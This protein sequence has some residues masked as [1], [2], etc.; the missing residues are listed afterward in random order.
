VRAAPGARCTGWSRRCGS[1]QP[2]SPTT[3]PAPTPKA[4]YHG[5]RIATKLKVAGV[6]LAS[7]GLKHPEKEDDEFVRFSEPRRGVYKSVVIRDGKLG[8]HP[9]RRRREGR[10]TQSFDRGLPLPEERVELLFELAGSSGQEGAAEMDDS[11]QVCNCNGVSKGDLVACVRSGT[12]NVSG[13]MAATR[14]GKGCGV[15]KGLVGTVFRLRA[16]RGI[17]ALDAVCLHAGGPLADAQIDHMKI[18]CPLHSYTFSLSDGACRGGDLAVR[19]YPV[20][21][22]DGE[23]VVALDERGR[24]DFGRLQQRMHVIRPTLALLADVPVRYVVFDVL[25]RGGMPLLDEPYLA[26]RAV[27]AELDLDAR[28]FQTSPMFTDTPGGIVMTAARQQGIEGVIAKRVNSV[29]QPGRRSRAWIKTPIRYTAEVVLVAW[30]ASTGNERV[31]GSLLRGATT[32]PA[33]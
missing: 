27:L 3:S 16:G 14:A 4:A 6:G 5:S 9:A 31:L 21:E 2:C 33:T 7:I 22:E 20:R 1:R 25:R 17:R 23:I 10:L 19:T 29:Y 15:C 30:A 18:V 32:L 12:R 28:G 11:V 26:R 24:P 13:V 8:C